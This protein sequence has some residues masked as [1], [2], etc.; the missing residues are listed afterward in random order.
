MEWK[1]FFR[2]TLNWFRWPGV[3]YRTH[4]QWD[5]VGQLPSHGGPSRKALE[6]PRMPELLRR[7]ASVSLCPVPDHRNSLNDQV[8][9]T[10]ARPKWL[11]S[12]WDRHKFTLAARRSGSA[13]LEYSI[14]FPHATWWLGNDPKRSRWCWVI[15]DLNPAQPM[16]RKLPRSLTACGGG[17]M[18]RPMMLFSFVLWA[19]LNSW[20]P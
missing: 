18:F 4:R 6:H 10:E 19:P 7:T 20:S 9:S 12:Y 14:A 13:L 8:P 15:T 16:V 1:I 5:R 3:S 17:G 2:L 11:R